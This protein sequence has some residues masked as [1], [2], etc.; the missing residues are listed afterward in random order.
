MHRKC[1]KNIASLI[2]YY[3][4]G[5]KESVVEGKTGVFFDKL[6]VKSLIQAIEKFEHTTISSA[7]CITQARKFSKEE[8]NKRMTAIVQKYFP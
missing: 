5:L 8:F 4:G 2:A 7:S 3:S 6:E 1:N